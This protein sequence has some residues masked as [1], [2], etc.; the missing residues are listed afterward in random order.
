M[1][2]RAIHQLVSDED[3][4]NPAGSHAMLKNLPVDDAITGAE[5]VPSAIVLRE[6]LRALFRKGCFSSVNVQVA[7]KGVA[8]REGS[9]SSHRI[10][11]T[12][13]DKRLKY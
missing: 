9:R 6:Q 10:F 8:V 7:L 1:A 13:G 4:P 3:T 11:S 2:I 5:D 12:M